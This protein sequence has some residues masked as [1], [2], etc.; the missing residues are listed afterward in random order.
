MDGG[1]YDNQAVQSI[2]DWVEDQTGDRASRQGLFKRLIV[3]KEQPVP[4]KP[5]RAAPLDFHGSKSW[6]ARPRDRDALT[7]PAGDEI[8]LVFVCDSPLRR[9]GQAIYRMPKEKERGNFSLKLIAIINLVFLSLSALSLLGIIGKIL[10]DFSIVRSATVLELIVFGLPLVVLVGVVAVVSYATLRLRKGLNTCRQVHGSLWPLIRALRVRDIRD[11]ISLRVHSTFKTVEPIMTTRM[12]DLTY[13]MLKTHPR[14]HAET[15]VTNEMHDLLDELPSEL[16][17]WLEPSER[18]QAVARRVA[19][20][21]T[22]LWV[23]PAQLRELVACG[24][25]TTCYNL[26]AQLLLNPNLYPRDGDGVF[27]TPE[28]RHVFAKFYDEWERMKHD[29]LFYVP[30]NGHA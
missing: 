7:E 25:F 11:M 2:I 18:M 20:M 29:P 16:P 9:Y 5:A 12:R 26:L 21:E 1:I 24:Q 22:E 28:H 10:L 13:Q 3:S 19:A 15:I 23:E 30:A 27:S 17:P 14:I 4:S 6:W 8:G